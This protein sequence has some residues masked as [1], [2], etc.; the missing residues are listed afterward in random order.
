MKKRDYGIDLLRIFSMGLIILHHLLTHGGLLTVFP[1]FST[2]GLAVH[3]INAFCR[4][5]VNAYALI[6]GYVMVNSAFRSSRLIALWLEA[7]FYGVLAVLCLP[8]MSPE[9]ATLGD[10]LSALLPVMNDSY[11]YFTCYVAIS[12]LSPFL[13]L[14]LHTMNGRQTRMMMTAILVLFSVLPML[15][16]NDV[17][18]LENGYH[19]FW[20]MILYLL[21]GYLRLYG[22]G[23][24]GQKWIALLTLVICTLL[25]WAGRLG[26]IV[27]G[28]GVGSEMVLNYNSPTV[29][30]C[31][32]ALLSLFR[33]IRLPAWM[34]KTIGILSPL[35][36]GVYLIHDN[37]LVRKYLIQS[38]MTPLSEGSPARL[39]IGLAAC[40]AGIYAICLLVEW[41]RTKLFQF[42]RIPVLCARAEQRIQAWSER[43]F[44]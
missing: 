23:C 3:L 1:R 15:A 2:S 12:L 30:L 6:S 32:V 41:L 28:A 40:W 31:G 16:L 19:F 42:L 38:S 5:S 24:L 27:M 10:W 25:G 14:L 43:L 18:H 21:G 36:F 37:E 33:E 4:S 26:L 9:A 11:W 20:L 22:F 39:L 17:F 7:V 35:T 8:L 34:Q 29:L 13:N 44:T